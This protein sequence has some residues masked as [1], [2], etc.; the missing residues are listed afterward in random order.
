LLDGD[1]IQA[2][3]NEGGSIKATRSQTAD[4]FAC[5][6]SPRLAIRTAY[7]P[8]ATAYSR[9]R[10]LAAATAGCLD[11][12][13]RGYLADLRRPSRLSSNLGILDASAR[14]HVARR[15]CSAVEIAA[16]TDSGLDRTPPSILADR[17]ALHLGISNSAKSHAKRR[18][19]RGAPVR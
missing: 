13:A 14:S 17:L 9:H 16:I 10:S 18:I 4:R 1:Q 8:G 7:W 12:M 6:E 2:K 15:R 5:S 11:K 3:T 19:K